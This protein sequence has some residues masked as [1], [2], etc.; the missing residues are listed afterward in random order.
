MIFEIFGWIGMGVTVLA[1]GMVNF[2]KL[3]KS[4]FPLNSIAAV[5]LMAYELSIGAWPVFALHSFLLLTSSI[6]SIEVL[7]K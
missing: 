2:K 4:F 7:R 5:F 6:K 3:E 1:F